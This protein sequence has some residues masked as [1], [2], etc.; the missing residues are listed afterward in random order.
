[1]RLRLPQLGQIPVAA[2]RHR[3]GKPLLRLVSYCRSHPAAVAV[4]PVCLSQAWPV[5]GLVVAVGSRSKLEGWGKHHFAGAHLHFASVLVVS[6][7][8]QTPPFFGGGAKNRAAAHLAR[9]EAPCCEDLSCRVQGGVRQT[10]HAAQN[11]GFGRGGNSKGL[12][13]F[14]LGLG[15][16]G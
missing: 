3:A 11:L 8:R 7:G 10:E 15:W 9:L 16:V 6:K 14:G 12:G 2:S 4:R 5:G 1:M 13:L